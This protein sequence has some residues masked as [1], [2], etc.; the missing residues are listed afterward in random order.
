MRLQA[1]HSYVLHEA[2]NPV[3]NVFYKFRQPLPQDFRLVG[4]NG[5]TAIGIPDLG[6]FPS[7]VLDGVSALH[8]AFRPWTGLFD[9]LRKKRVEFL[10]CGQSIRKRIRLLKQ[11]ANISA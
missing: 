10:H 4:L 7:F 11:E 1:V 6:E 3:Q 9:V 8:Q 2:N 5:S